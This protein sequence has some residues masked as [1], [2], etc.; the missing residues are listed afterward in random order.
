MAMVKCVNAQLGISSDRIKKNMNTKQQQNYKLPPPRFDRED[1]IYFLT[2]ITYKRQKILH[3]SGVPEIIINALHFY[4]TKILKFQVL[5]S[6]EY[7]M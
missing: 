1:S 3:I 4:N 5:V 7:S 6:Y 2:I